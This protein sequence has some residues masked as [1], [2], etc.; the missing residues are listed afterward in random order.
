M[1]EHMLRRFSHLPVPSGKL[2]AGIDFFLREN[3][4]FCND[5]SFSSCFPFREMGLDQSFFQQKVIPSDGEVY[6]TGP[7]YLA[8]DLNA[9]FIEMIA[10][11]A[12][13]SA[14][15]ARDIFNYWEPLGADCIRVLRKPSSSERGIP[16]QLIFAFP[17]RHE[18]RKNDSLMMESVDLVMINQSS[19]AESMDIII[20]SYEETW[21]IN[22]Q[23]LG[24]LQPANLS[25][26]TEAINRGEAYMI[27]FRGKIAGIIICRCTQR[28]F[29]H[30]Y[31]IT[32][33]V[34][35]PQFR[36]QSLASNA[37]RSL[38]KMITTHEKGCTLFGCIANA[39]IPS[40]L[41]AR[42]AGRECILEYAFMSREDLNV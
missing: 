13:L 29:L 14:R 42:R 8:G 39:N 10:S 35:L 37:Q 20:Y 34:I 32:E 9:P 41:S 15:S 24:I 2:N 19:L 22:P 16:N 26:L 33:E 36:G 11:S 31:W 12:P 6:L 30:G 17:S 7:R 40:A 18:E 23:L 25:E 3:L 28:G 38:N 1:L 4:R 27:Y 5:P 21:R